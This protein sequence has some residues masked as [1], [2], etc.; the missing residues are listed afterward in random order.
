[1]QSFFDQNTK[2]I[3]QMFDQWRKMLGGE[4]A[5]PMTGFEHYQS[6]MSSF[7]KSVGETYSSN[8][9][10]WNGFVEQGQESFL[11]MCESSPIRNESAEQQFRDGFETVTTARKTIQEM[12]KSNLT[13]LAKH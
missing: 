8:A 1:M 7:L 11:K 13:C 10:A 4:S 3:E 5:W 9:D 6:N 2:M 12:V